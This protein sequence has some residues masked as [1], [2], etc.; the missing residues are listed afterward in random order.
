MRLAG[1]TGGVVAVVSVVS[2]GLLDWWLVADD[3]APILVPAAEIGAAVGTGVQ[4]AVVAFAGIDLARRRTRL[5]S[6]R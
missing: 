4:F 2:V 3:T 5:L 1:L 6:L